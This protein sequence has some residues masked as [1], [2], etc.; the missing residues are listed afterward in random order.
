MPLKK[1]TTIP[2][3]DGPMKSDGQVIYQALQEDIRLAA[4]LK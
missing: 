1:D 4:I 3:V 2:K